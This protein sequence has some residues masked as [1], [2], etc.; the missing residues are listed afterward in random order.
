MLYMASVHLEPF[1][2]SCS[3]FKT[4]PRYANEREHI[5]YK[6]QGLNLMEANHKEETTNHEQIDEPAG[7]YI[8][9]FFP[10]I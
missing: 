9:V 5:R 8:L 2:A 4:C 3:R 10:I 7:F 1:L 6:M